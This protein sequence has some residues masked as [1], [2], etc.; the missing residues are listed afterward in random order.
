[1]FYCLAE[2]VSRADLDF[3]P[4]ISSGGWDHLRK[5]IR[6][7]FAGRRNLG[8]QMLEVVVFDAASPGEAEREFAALLPTLL[9]VPDAS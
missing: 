8:Q 3:N 6:V 1:V 9:R 2:D 7:A 5:R 4:Y